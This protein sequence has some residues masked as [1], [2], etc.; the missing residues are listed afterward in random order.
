MGDLGKAGWQPQRALRVRCR[1]GT[2]TPGHKLFPVPRRGLRRAGPSTG[3][4]TR[5]LW[6]GVGM[7]PGGLSR[8]KC[9]RTG[10]SL[11]EEGV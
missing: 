7:E 9:G 6:G 3:N 1:S 10:L 4:E 2:G 5:C 8:S 11:R